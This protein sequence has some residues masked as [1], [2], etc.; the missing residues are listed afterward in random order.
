[1]SVEMQVETRDRAVV[2]Q[3]RGL[4]YSFSGTGSTRRTVN[5]WCLE[6]VSRFHGESEA[7]VSA[8]EE[9]LNGDVRNALQKRKR[10]KFRPTCLT[11]A[12]SPGNSPQ[13][14]SS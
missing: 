5:A 7:F 10:D 8:R 3:T 12:H 6:L 11:F 4:T 9:Q 2:F 14:V 1:M 13:S